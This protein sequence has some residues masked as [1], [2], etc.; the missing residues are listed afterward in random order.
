MKGFAKVDY[1]S[2]R[3]AQS[4][5]DVPSSKDSI[6]ALGNDGTSRKSY[7]VQPETLSA[8]KGPSVK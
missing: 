8:E 5:A 6:G 7:K 3:P 4:N 1:P 2:E